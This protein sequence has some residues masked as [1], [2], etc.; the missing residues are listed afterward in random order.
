MA[1][2]VD[3]RVDLPAVGGEP[4]R[5]PPVEVAREHFEIETA[6]AALEHR[7][8]PDLQLLSRVHQRFPALAVDP[9]QQE[10]FDG[11]AARLAPSEQARRHYARVVDHHDVARREQAGEVG[12]GVVRPLSRAA[13]QPQ[14]T[15]RIAGGRH[16]LG[17]QL[18]GQVVVEV[19]QVHGRAGG[20]LSTP[21]AA[22]PRRR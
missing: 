7:A 21:S 17:D 4:N 16:L 8:R 9:A 12:H 14:E 3:G 11:A 6:P 2:G 18:P 5:A 20:P 10:T 22:A 15:R 1:D 13:I 19:R